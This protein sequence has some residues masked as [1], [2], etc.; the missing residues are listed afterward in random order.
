MRP[1]IFYN[2]NKKQQ[3]DAVLEQI[4]EDYNSDEIKDAF[5]ECVVPRQL[6]F[7][8]GGENGNFNQAIEFLLPSSQNRAFFPFLLSDQGQNLMT[9]NSLSI[10]IGSDDIFYQ[11]FNTGK[12]FYNFIFRIS[13]HHSFENT[14]RTFYLPFQLTMSKN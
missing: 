4:K 11:N 10:H 12:I 6:D 2:V 14:Y 9:N 5:D 8:C 13:Y 3:E 7:F 1:S